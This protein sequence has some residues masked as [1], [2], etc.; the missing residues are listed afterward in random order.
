[1]LPS[2]IYLFRRAANEGYLEPWQLTLAAAAGV[3]TAWPTLLLLVV[4]GT[5]LARAFG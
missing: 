4:L 2:G 3:L 5:I 1:L